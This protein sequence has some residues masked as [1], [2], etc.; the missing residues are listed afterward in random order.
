[1]LL[2]LIWPHCFW[3]ARSWRQKGTYHYQCE[4]ASTNTCA[5]VCACM[6]ARMRERPLLPIYWFHIVFLYT[7]LFQF[8]D[9]S[10]QSFS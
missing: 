7:F 5:R 1:M 10:H 8:H 6:C 2:I 3:A 4:S 9:L